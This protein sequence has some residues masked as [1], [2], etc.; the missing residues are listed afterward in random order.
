MAPTPTGPDRPRSTRTDP[1]GIGP[2]RPT[3]RLRPVDLLSPTGQRTLTPGDGRAPLTAVAPYVSVLATPTPT[4][5]HVRIT[6][7][8]GTD[9]LTVAWEAGRVSLA[10]TTAEGTTEHRSRRFGR[11]DQRPDQV[12]LTLTGT[13]LTAFVREAGSWVARG[14][15][16]LD[17]RVPTRDEE[18]LAGLEVSTAGDVEEL[19]AGPFGQLG[20]RDVRL[21]TTTDGS[22][23][24]EGDLV[25]FTATSAGPG[26]FDT[27]HTSVWSFDTV[28]D[29]LV[30]RAHLY[31]RREGEPGVHGDHATHLVRHEDRWLVT[32]ST[33]GDFVEPATRAARRT[34][35]RLRVTVAESSEDLLVGQHVLTMRD[36]PLPTDGFTSVGVWD[37]HLVRREGTWWVGYVSASRFFRFHPVLASGPSLDDLTLVAADRSR[38]ATEGTT[39][40]PLDDGLVVL[41]SDGR[42]GQRGRRVAYPVLDTGLRQ[43]GRLDAP[44]GTNIPWPTLVP[45]AREGDPWLMLTFDGTERDPGLLGYGTHGDLVVMRGRGS[46]SAED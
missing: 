31:F 42:D 37:S 16:E 41:A 7:H 6:L 34:R 9:E 26:F 30:H 24:R 22:P 36:L 32:T 5:D 21:V 20:L 45:P 8:A 44:Y 17:G 29:E 14:R 25:W 43:T 19:R 46:R 12:A 38:T 15:V 11:T 27:A 3:A 35:S 4:S 10:V 40:L 1:T 18:W 39:L 13:H 23:L 33:W 2:L 28:T